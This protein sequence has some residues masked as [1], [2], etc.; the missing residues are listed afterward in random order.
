M[1]TGPQ[2]IDGGTGG[3]WFS[4]RSC[5]KAF[6]LEMTRCRHCGH[7]HTREELEML[8]LELRNKERRALLV[9]LIVFPLFLFLVYL[10]IQG[11]K[12]PV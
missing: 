7:Q 12:A 8:E 6:S 10:F 4:C 1:E 3:R 11:L 2:E 5:G 9:G